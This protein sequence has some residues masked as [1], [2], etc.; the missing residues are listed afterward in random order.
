MYMGLL[1]EKKL[2]AR[3]GLVFV[4]E[5]DAACGKM[6]PRICAG[7]ERALLMERAGWRI[8]ERLEVLLIVPRKMSIAKG[9]V[10]GFIR[11]LVE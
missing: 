9:T 6:P 10:F 5:G 8:L 1:V 2:N 4:D 11:N 7:E 3:L